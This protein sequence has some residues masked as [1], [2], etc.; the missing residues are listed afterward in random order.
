MRLGPHDALQPGTRVAVGD[1]HGEVVKVETVPAHPAGMICVH[2][3]KLTHERVHLYG[4]HTKMVAIE[5]PQIIRPNY[6]FLRT[7]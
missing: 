1:K 2:T 7:I 5:P 4:R 3:V 6:A